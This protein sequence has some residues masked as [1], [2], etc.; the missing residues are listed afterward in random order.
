M[1][2]AR[3]YSLASGLDEHQVWTEFAAPLLQG[4]KPNVLAICEYGFTEMLNNVI[5]HSGSPDVLLRV[6][7]PEDR[8]EISLHDSG[9]GVFRKLQVGL[10]LESEHAA[11]LELAKGRVTTDPARH[12]GEGIFFTARM[13]DR[14]KLLSGAMLSLFKSGEND[15]WIE[16]ETD[17]QAGTHVR[18]EIDPKSERTTR[19]VF[20]RFA[21]GEEGFRFDTT[22]LALRLFGVD[23]RL[24]SRS[25]AKRLLAR[26]DQFRTVILDFEGIED[27]GPAF[28]DELFRVFQRSNPGVHIVPLNA[29]E[30]VNQAILRVLTRNGNAR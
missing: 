24:V 18:M 9:V 28:A 11:A 15:W 17:P 10:G 22:V 30:N 21:A 8:V 26:L 7:T 16:N 23:A 27:I 19:E 29:N 20:D 2:Q 13:F 14:F 1:N 3:I 4:L 25:Q 6:E 5:D 12:T